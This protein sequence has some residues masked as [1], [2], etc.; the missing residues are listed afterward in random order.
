MNNG[1]VFPPVPW[2][3][4]HRGAAGHAPENTLAG[5]RKAAALGAKW[6]E[7]DV[8]L[9]MDGQPV[10]LHDETVDRTTGGTG[11]VAALMY[12]SLLSFDAGGWFHE[13]FKGERIP[14]LSDAI[15]L[16][17]ELGLGAI[18]E[19]KPNPGQGRLTGHTVGQFLRENWPSGFVAPLISSFETDALAAV[20]EAAP[21]FSRALNVR[22]FPGD[23]PRSMNSLGCVSLHASQMYLSE[24]NVRDVRSAGYPLLSFTVNR[25]DKANRLKEWGVHGVFTDYPDR[26]LG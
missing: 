10:L 25:K 23:W 17:Y 14:H 2:V 1:S 13:K 3:I 12:N 7:F 20:R 21:Q 11:T 24:K 19:L 16:V 4:G 9:S 6:V 26:L 18:V 15:R 5:I 22:Q 8:R